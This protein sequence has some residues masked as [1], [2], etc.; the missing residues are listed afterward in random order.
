MDRKTNDDKTCWS[1]RRSYMKNE[2][3]LGLCPNCINKYGSLAASVGALGLAYGG[4][5]FIKHSGKII[6]NVAEVAKNI[7]S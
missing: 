6:R 3:K 2:G 7:K 1:C 4:K 5:Q